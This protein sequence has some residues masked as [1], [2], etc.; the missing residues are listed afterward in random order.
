MLEKN[1]TSSI[2]NGFLSSWVPRVSLD[3]IHLKQLPFYPS[4]KNTFDFSDDRNYTEMEWHWQSVQL[5]NT[6]Y[7]STIATEEN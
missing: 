3:Q 5:S 1:N 6:V 2:F 7:F 4:C